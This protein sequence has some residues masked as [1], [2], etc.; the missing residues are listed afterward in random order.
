M[1]K[2]ILS[3]SLSLFFLHSY[4]QEICGNGMDDDGDGLVDCMD[5]TDCT[6]SAVPTGAFFNTA[7]NGVGGVLLG[8]S[9]DTHWQ[10]STGSLAGPYTPAI[11]MGSI[12]GSYFAS[13]WPDC[14]WISHAIDG[15]HFINTDYYYKIEFYL[16]CYTACGASYS[17]PGTFCLSMDFFSDNSV[18][19]V[20]I[21]GVPQ[22]ASLAGVPAT[23]PYFNV[24]FSAAGGLSFSLC[25]GWQPGL[26]VL[27]FKIAS[28]PGNAG[29]LA[30]NST[31]LPPSTTD[32][33]ILSPFSNYA[34]CDTSSLVTF[35]AAST[36]GTW[37]ATCGSCI[38]AT[39]G[40]FDPSTISPGIYTVTYTITTPC[41]ASDTASIQLLAAAP[42]ATIN[43]VSSHCINDAPFNFTSVTP[44]GTWSGI[45]ITNSATG[46]FNPA[47]AGA[48]TLTI[49]HIFSGTCPDTATQT[50]TIYT[51]PTP[52]ITSNINNG[53]AP[54]CV[55]FNE[56]VGTSCAN[57]VYYFG[58]GDSALSTTPIHC[59][60]QDSVYSVSI[61]CTD[62]QGCVGTTTIPNMITVFNTPVANFSIAPA[63]PI[64]TNTL[65][66]FTNTTSGSN[67]YFWSFDD[68]TSGSSNT[69]TL[70]S[71]SH[72]YINEGQYC[73]LLIASNANGCIDSVKYCLI[74]EGESTI[75][76]PNVFTPNSDLSN[77]LF[78]VSS[79][80]IKTISYSIYDRWGLKI[81]EH[82]GI[83]GG[84]NGTVKNGRT[85]P[86]GTYYY[87][88]K[89]TT[90]NG[91][92]IEKEGYLQLLAE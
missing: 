64:N 17:T 35:T 88:L 37:S 40:V 84:W 52:N 74:V 15:A 14:N 39:T 72:T 6:S 9:T 81:A 56:T 44:G 34:T 78:L 63:S 33:T 21:N 55:Q 54:L 73:A 70:T 85:A 24:G 41:I 18:D 49:T 1:K 68:V 30:Q 28:G 62:V 79:Y 22:S 2:I 86:D 82:N 7:T 89:A 5:T 71:P 48:G 12:P 66:N 8:G 31:T 26:N 36:G 83:T 51:L 58:D 13:P 75:F 59:Y 29:F 90:D 60:N 65:V 11:V 80:H 19:E 27:I 16:P 61:Q 32:P 43:P 77:D 42:D 76:I 57:V 10:L 25:N 46:A 92:L 91:K 4:S 50:I 67:S 69:S 3:L 23:D 47:F 20:Y 45:G 87:I 38:N 53:C